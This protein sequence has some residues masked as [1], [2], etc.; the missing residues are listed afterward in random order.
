MRKQH[1]GRQLGLTWGDFSARVGHTTAQVWSLMLG[2]RDSHGLCHPT[3]A[4]IARK[5]GVSTSRVAKALARL[6][7]LGIV[8]P[9]GRR[10]IVVQ[11]RKRGIPP[12]AIRVYHWCVV[13]WVKGDWRDPE[14]VVL[15]RPVA[16]LVAEAYAN[17]GFRPGAGRPRKAAE[18]KA[19]NQCGSPISSK[20]KASLLL[21]R[22]TPTGYVPS[23]EGTRAAPG[24]CAAGAAAPDV[25][26][27]SQAV[28]DARAA[29]YG[30]GR[31][32][33]RRA[34]YPGGQPLG[35]AQRQDSRHKPA[36]LYPV[37]NGVTHTRWTEDPDAQPVPAAVK[38]LNASAMRS[39]ELWLVAMRPLIPPQPR[40]PA[41]MIPS[42]PCLREGMSDA[43]KI[44]MLTRAFRAA[45]ERVFG[46][47]THVYR[48]GPPRN[49]RLRRSLLCAA[50]VMIEYSIS[51]YTWA[52]WRIRW[53]TGRGRMERSE[54]HVPNVL[55]AA[56]VRKAV[57]FYRREC[58]EPP[59][60][61]QRVAATEELHSRY[62]EMMRQLRRIAEIGRINHAVIEVTRA[63]VGQYFPEDTYARDVEAATAAA[64]EAQR[65]INYRLARGDW[66]WP[67]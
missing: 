65:H 1:K 33:R 5:L 30:Y 35:A 50:D 64:R 31:Q 36:H 56:T 32:A 23:E 17:G 19:E 41:V 13:G 59:R 55:S 54:I 57:T 48:G 4:G 26:F 47:P 14:L 16:R 45:Y 10:V 39:V 11:S 67:W 38:R 18:T 63:V 25:L 42:P 46:V 29:R 27:A 58:S 28:T 15:P 2:V 21:R 44:A 62:C 24:G 12:T 52:E 51:P 60:V 22:H 66:I 9:L 34:T 61:V 8:R 53:L 7:R 20:I 3:R 37:R 49:P 6:R 43:D 40:I